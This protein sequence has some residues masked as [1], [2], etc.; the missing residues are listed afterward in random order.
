MVPGYSLNGVNVRTAPTRFLEEQA[1]FSDLARA[2]GA[3]PVIFEGWGDDQKFPYI[4]YASVEAARSGHALL[5]PI[6][7]VWR[8]VQAQGVDLVST[9]NIHPNVTG[10]WLMAATIAETLFPESAKN[11][12]SAPPAGVTRRNASNIRTAAVREVYRLKTD[13]MVLPPAPEYATSIPDLQSDGE[14]GEN[15][16][17]RWC[18]Q[19]GGIRLSF[20][21]ELDIRRDGQ[22]QVSMKD[23]STSALLEPKVTDLRVDERSAAFK[24]A[25]GS[26]HY[27]VQFAP[28]KDALQVLT[29]YDTNK[30][31]RIFRSVAYTRECGQYFDRLHDLY[32]TLSTNEQKV[33]LAEALKLH[34]AQL[35]D[36][37][38]EATFTRNRQGFPV[39]EWDPIMVGMY[40]SD[41]GAPARALDYYKA[42]V[43]M[44]PNSVDAN[45]YYGKGL[46]A[47]WRR[48]DAR[49]A[50]TR[51]LTLNSGKSQEMASMIEAELAGL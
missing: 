47:L 44:T 27:D 5:A 32:A 19:D 42:A 40:Y 21:T 7:R 12:Q 46:A 20:G 2:N 45:F 17:G 26:V 10:T 28:H 8:D 38:D 13:G 29:G 31:H 34:Y 23:F 16:V 22:L 11:I 30:T 4:D 6:G 50:Y 37:V 41:S 25:A 9:D 49:A 51:A 43:D 35:H 33:G 18:A 14:I 15:V 3:K 48:A 36:L 39:S 24:V 1:W